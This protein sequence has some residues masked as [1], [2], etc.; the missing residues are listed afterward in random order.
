MDVRL[1]N[2]LLYDDVVHR[3]ATAALRRVIEDDE[4]AD[5]FREAAAFELGWRESARDG[6]E[7]G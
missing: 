7:G 3:L 1:D 6:S 5:S 4:F 2:R